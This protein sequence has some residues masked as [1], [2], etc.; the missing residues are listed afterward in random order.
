MG[1]PCV[2]RGLAVVR[3][4]EFTWGFAGGLP[5]VCPRLAHGLAMGWPW[6]A[7]ESPTGCSRL[8][9]VEP[10]VFPMETAEEVSHGFPTP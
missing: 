9:V 1:H 10:N 7:R 4:L 3:H 8:S 5:M 6:A 2:A